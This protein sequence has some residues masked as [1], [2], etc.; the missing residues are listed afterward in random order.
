MLLNQQKEKSMPLLIQQSAW[1]HLLQPNWN[2]LPEKPLLTLLLVI[3]WIRQI[4]HVT[5]VV[6]LKVRVY[7]IFID[8]YVAMDHIKFMHL[9]NDKPIIKVSKLPLST[10]L[11]TPNHCDALQRNYAVFLGREVVRFVS[12]FKKFNQ[13]VPDH[14][15]HEHTNSK[16]FVVKFYTIPY[17]VHV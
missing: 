2:K 10:F 8:S 14:I 5:Q 9:S 17:T 16:S 15:T 11:P 6:I 13:Y 7:T 12:Y 4:N 3:F 1:F